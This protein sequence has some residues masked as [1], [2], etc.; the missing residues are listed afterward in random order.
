M[1]NIWLIGV[2]TI[3]IEYTKVLKKIGCNIIAI[4]RGSESARKYQDETGIEPIEGGLDAFLSTLPTPPSHAII[5]VNLQQLADTALAL[6]KYGVKN[7]LCEKPGFNSPNEL[8]QVYQCAKSYKANVYYAYNRRFYCNVHTGTQQKA[9]AK[10]KSVKIDLY[11]RFFNF[12]LLTI[13]PCILTENI[14]TS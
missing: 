2:G 9:K 6:I 11:I 3:G 10:G 5:A 1:K 7:I 12:P 4:G 13:L 14:I 8:E